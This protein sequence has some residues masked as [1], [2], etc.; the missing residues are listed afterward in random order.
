MSLRSRPPSP[1]R[2]FGAT[3]LGVF[4]LLAVVLI[5]GVAGL[6]RSPIRAA[7]AAPCEFDNVERVVAVGD[8]HGA[9]DRL[10]EILRAA[11]VIDTRNRWIGG[12][13]HLVQTGDVLDRGPDSRQ[14]LEFLRRL[15]R[16]A[17]RQ[18][19]K[20]HA[21]IGNHE[22]MRLLG[23]FRYVVPGEYARFVDTDSEATRRA[24]IEKS[25]AEQ[26]V[27]LEAETPLGMI[28]MIRAVSPGQDLGKYLRTLD[29][30]VRINGIVF[31]HG[32]ISPAVAPMTCTEIND[33]VRRELGPD[34]EQTRAKPS[35]SLA[36]R[37]DGPLWYRG[38]A[39][40]PE[41]FAPEVKKILAAQHA[42]AIVVAHSASPGPIR[43]RFDNTIFVI[44]TGMQPAY[45]P[46]GR[47][48][49]LEIRG[50]TFTAIYT[51][52]RQVIAGGNGLSGGVR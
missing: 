51:D 47:A 23:D 27:R 21:L 2:G 11:A 50:G 32:G 36:A 41:G 8:V 24:V 1:L 34:F 43:N 3:G 16:E 20:V 22:V 52:S 7:A 38:L 10:L 29:A 14:A 31:V 35:E 17:D 39:N 46:N 45:L 19:G 5:F 28:E 25:P 4:A 12:R 6:D 44:D 49:A 40:E 48:S 30:V 37:E 9:Y 26:R 33:T 18:G 15:A 13:T 42:R